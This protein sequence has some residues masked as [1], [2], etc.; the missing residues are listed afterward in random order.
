MSEIT[1][2]RLQS[3]EV[4]NLIKEGFDVPT[5]IKETNKEAYTVLAISV[6]ADRLGKITRSCRAVTKGIM[7]MQKL[8]IYKDKA[9]MFNAQRAVILHDPTIAE[10]VEE[11][12][13]RGRKA[14]DET[15]EETK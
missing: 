1:P 14:K 5:T 15:T 11:K 4:Q 10:V 2:N 8:D 7:S 13:K 6:E 9:S 3:K 12:P